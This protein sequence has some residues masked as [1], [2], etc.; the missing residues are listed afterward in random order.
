M[1]A[2]KKA[3]RRKL[4][5]LDLARDL[6]DGSRACRLMGYSRQQL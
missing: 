5:L 4:L 1:A 3:A 6:V 2:Q